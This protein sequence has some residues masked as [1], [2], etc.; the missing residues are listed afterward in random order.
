MSD[1]E[2][3][4]FRRYLRRALSNGD[5]GG[6]T[7]AQLLE[8]FIAHRDEAAFE[9]LVWRHGPKVLGVCRSVLRHEQDAEDAF[10]ATFLVLVRKGRSIGK[11]EAVGSWLYRVAYRVAL[12]AKVMAD[13]RAAR[14]ARIAVEAAAPSPPDAVWGDLRPVLDQEIDRLPHK[15]RAA[16]VLCYLD[17][18][19]NEE[20]ARELGCPKGTVLSR[21]AW[22]RER[23]RVRLTRRGLDLSATLPLAALAPNTPTTPLPAALVEATLKAALSGAGQASLV[24]GPV[25]ALT[26]GVVQTMLWTKVKIIAGCMLAVGVLVLGGVLMS[27]AL[28]AGPSDGQPPDG[29][30][31]EKPGK[32]E[33]PPKADNPPEK[34]DAAADKAIAFELRDKPWASVFEWY[35]EVSGLAYAGSYKPQGTATFIPARGKRQYTLTEITDI[36]NEMLISQKYI[37]I[38]RDVTFTVLPADEKID[39]VLVPRV[40]V[41]DLGKRG[42]TELVSVVLSVTAPPAKDLGPDVKKMLGPFGEIVVLEKANQFIL[43][44]TAGNLRQIYETLKVVQADYAERIRESRKIIEAEQQKWLELQKKRDPNKQ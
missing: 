13:K 11:R 37:L 6:L 25:A 10:Q 7:D 2:Q 35:S 32:V 29:T 28:E 20:A 39:P 30:Q 31:A 41:D 23:L 8:R 15:Y 5:A 14:Q 43:Q 34:K 3:M 42:K 36:L 38:R 27:H 1:G 26:A 9:V 24:S 12:R 19:T 16:F 21:L 33:P 22:A 18:K 40:R 4:L 17:G 44:D